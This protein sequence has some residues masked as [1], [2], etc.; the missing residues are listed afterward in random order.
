MARQKRLVA[1]ETADR[2]WASA[3]CGIG[4]TCVAAD[5]SEPSHV[6]APPD[7][8]PAMQKVG[9]VHETA[10]TLINPLRLV[11]V[12]VAPSQRYASPPLARD[13]GEPTA[14]QNRADV[15]ETLSRVKSP[16]F[17]APAGGA[18]VSWTPGDQAEP[19][20]RYASPCL[21]TAAQN[22]L[23]GHETASSAGAPV[24]VTAGELLALAWTGR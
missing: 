22:R 5:H 19:C 15:H 13:G 7:P 11:A 10:S 23:D 2:G 16:G 4:V 20:H 21:S 3:T 8:S 17:G 24:S 18:N 6:Y 9:L 12:Q 1:H 14:M